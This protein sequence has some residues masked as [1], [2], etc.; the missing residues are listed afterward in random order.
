VLVDQ[1]CVHAVRILR[2]LIFGTHDSDS[3][4]D[5]P[6]LDLGRDCVGQQ[7]RCVRGLSLVADCIV[8][9]CAWLDGPLLDY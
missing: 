5:V 9:G 8:V 7:S 6:V 3:S 2:R 1:L 4:S